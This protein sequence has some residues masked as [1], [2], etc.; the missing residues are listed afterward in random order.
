MI[1][2]ISKKDVINAISKELME[3]RIGMAAAAAFLRLRDYI[4]K[5]PAVKNRE[6]TEWIPCSEQLP[7]EGEIVL[8]SIPADRE[9]CARIAFGYFMFGQWKKSDWLGLIGAYGPMEPAPDAWMP[10]P[11]PYQ[12]ECCPIVFNHQ[13]VGYCDPEFHKLIENQIKELSCEVK[14]DE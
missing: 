5:M 1:D 13:T 6:R 14:V 10:M 4:E 12:A 2:L 7:E 9:Y 8:C 3:V 11:K